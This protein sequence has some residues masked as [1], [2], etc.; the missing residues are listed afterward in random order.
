MYILVGY[1]R[2][3]QPCRLNVTSILLNRLAIIFNA[4]FGAV[5]KNYDDSNV[6]SGSLSKEISKKRRKYKFA[7]LVERRADSD[8]LQKNPK[9]K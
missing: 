5:K 9:L 4:I 2:N 8:W 3:R 6:R 7:D 1:L